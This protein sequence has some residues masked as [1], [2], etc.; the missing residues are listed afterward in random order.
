MLRTPKS[1]FLVSLSCLFLR[2]R[3]PRPS[4]CQPDSSYK[5]DRC[6]D[7]IRPTGSSSPCLLNC[8]HSD[9]YLLSYSYWKTEMPSR[10][11]FLPQPR[12][13]PAPISLSC[14]LPSPVLICAS[15]GQTS[16]IPSEFPITSAF[17]LA[18]QVV[19]KARSK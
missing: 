4:P 16:R 3:A 2:C 19:S 14:I 8:R 11:R 15:S 10:H 12:I 18:S 17:R 9:G 1:S 7:R 5:L 6:K 13:I